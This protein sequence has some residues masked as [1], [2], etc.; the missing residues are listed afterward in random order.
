[1]VQHTLSYLNNDNTSSQLLFDFCLPF[2][3]L[4]E[5]ATNGVKRM[6]FTWLSYKQC[7]IKHLTNG[8]VHL[9]EERF[10]EHQNSVVQKY[11]V[12]DQS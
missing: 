2:K 10:S 8:L 12:V 5:Y 6:S 4:Q 7:L 1:M 9:T 3:W 11:I